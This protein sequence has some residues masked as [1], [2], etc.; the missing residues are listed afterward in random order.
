MSPEAEFWVLR[1]MEGRS[2]VKTRQMNNPKGDHGA[3]GHGTVTVT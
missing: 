3:E 2:S 1:P